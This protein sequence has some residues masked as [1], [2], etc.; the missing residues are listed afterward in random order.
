MRYEGDW[1]DG[2]CFIPNTKIDFSCN[3][4]NL[5]KVYYLIQLYIYA[6]TDVFSSQHDSMFYL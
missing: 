5:W 6:C 4:C 1:G 2:M 3:S